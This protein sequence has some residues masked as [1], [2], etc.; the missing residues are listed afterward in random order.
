MRKKKKV[1]QEAI[2]VE[3]AKKVVEKVVEVV[4]E[5]KIPV[6][7]FKVPE[8]KSIRIGRSVHTGRVEGGTLMTA[9]GV[10]FEYR[11]EL[12]V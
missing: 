2:P 8:L 10:G 5:K 11:P 1:E 12:E 4:K 9:N 3:P 7:G 6:K